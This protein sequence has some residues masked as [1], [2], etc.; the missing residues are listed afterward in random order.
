MTDCGVSLTSAAILSGACSRYSKHENIV[1]IR[2]LTDSLQSWSWPTCPLKLCVLE[3]WICINLTVQLH[4]VCLLSRCKNSTTMPTLLLTK[5][6]IDWVF[7]SQGPLC[8]SSD[9]Y[10]QINPILVVVT[11]VSQQFGCDMS[12]KSFAYLEMGTIKDSPRGSTSFEAFK[13]K[14]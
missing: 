5:Y 4:F 13:S 10:L 2:S 3:L 14:L 11:H 7:P 6:P 12:H 9:T 1:P 8:W